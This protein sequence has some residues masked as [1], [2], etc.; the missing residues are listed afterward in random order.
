MLQNS[1]SVDEKSKN[2]RF[3]YKV[4]YKLLSKVIYYN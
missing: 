3:K 1:Y 2:G 4:Y